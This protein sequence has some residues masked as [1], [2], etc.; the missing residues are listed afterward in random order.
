M[1]EADAATSFS[2]ALVSQLNGGNT[3]FMNVLSVLRGRILY[4]CERSVT[5]QGLWDGCTD[6]LAQRIAQRI[7]QQIDNLAGVCGLSYVGQTALA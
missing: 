6:S 4:L 3:K 7:F 2:V 1:T 5:V